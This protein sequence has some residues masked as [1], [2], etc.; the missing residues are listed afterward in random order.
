MKLRYLIPIAVALGGCVSAEMPPPTDVPQEDC[1]AGK[2]M[3]LKGEDAAALLDLN[4]PSN[5]RLVRPGMA[6]TQDY[7]LDRL[8]ISIDEKGLIDRIWCG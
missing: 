8:N 1:G 2:F 7:Q 5:H 3:H 4:L 6:Y